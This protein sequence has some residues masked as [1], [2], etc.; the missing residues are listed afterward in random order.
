MT[1]EEVLKE[2]MEEQ[3]AIY[4]R[5]LS[6]EAI[7]KIIESQPEVEGSVLNGLKIIIKTGDENTNRL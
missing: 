7:R 5:L 6:L 2:I 1:K 4:V 3:A